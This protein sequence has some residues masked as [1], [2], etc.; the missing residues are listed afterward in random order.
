V[1]YPDETELVGFLSRRLQPERARMLE[2]SVAIRRERSPDSRDLA[3]SL[4]WLARAHQGA[5][6]DDDAIAAFSEAR[7]IGQHRPDAQADYYAEAGLGAV[8]LDAGHPARALPHLERAI[9]LRT[10]G[11][12]DPAELADAQLD[13]ARGLVALHRDSRRAREL[14][15]AA[16]GV[17]VAAD[18]VDAAKVAQ[19]DATLARLLRR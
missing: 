13:L 19:V 11:E 5:K 9:A 1:E 10:T 16:R 6:R 8:H 12:Y 15:T 4:E 2:R 7:A 14:L 3:M 17:F 18:G